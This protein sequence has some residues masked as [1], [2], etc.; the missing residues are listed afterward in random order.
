MSR[1]IILVAGILIACALCAVIPAVSAAENPRVQVTAPA[2]VVT[3][4]TAPPAVQPETAQPAA[5]KT[6]DAKTAEPEPWYTPI[7]E[8]FGVHGQD[9]PRQVT[10]TAATNDNKNWWE[11]FI[12]VQETRVR[13]VTPQETPTEN[14]DTASQPQSPVKT[15][16]DAPSTPQNPA[17]NNSN[18][19]NN[20]PKVN[21]ENPQTPKTP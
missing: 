6:A 16:A 11:H 9:T 12:T 19:N 10:T 2:P 3:P 13:T 1:N 17:N 14:T 18:S 5:E 7:S 21:A 15:P 4:T 20:N 8:L